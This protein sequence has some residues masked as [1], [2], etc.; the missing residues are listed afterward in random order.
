MCVCVLCMCVCVCVCVCVCT[1]SVY[2]SV[3]RVVYCVSSKKFLENIF[4]T[5]IE[6]EGED[7]SILH[8][9]FYINEPR[10]FTLSQFVYLVC[11]LV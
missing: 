6:T 4:Y 1:C 11:F 9:S 8:I 2:S 5:C 3:Y 10:K 7:W